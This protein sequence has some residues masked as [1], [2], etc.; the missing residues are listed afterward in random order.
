MRFVMAAVSFLLVFVC[1]FVLAG[2]FLMPHLPPTPAE[3]VSAVEAGYWTTN[4]I[5]LALG[6]PAGLLS[7]RGT[8]KRKP[9]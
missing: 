4:W 6:L 2:W 8:L 5:G 1:V 7:A 9:V 3:P